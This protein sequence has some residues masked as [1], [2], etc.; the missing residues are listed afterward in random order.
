MVVDGKELI[1]KHDIADSLNE[2]FTT[3]ASSPLASQQSH[4]SPVDL[5]QDRLSA[6]S[7]HSFKFRAVSENDVFKVLRS[8]DTSKAIGA[9]AIPA[10]VIII[11]TLYIADLFN[12]SFPCGCFPS[13]LKTARVT[14]LFKGRSQTEHDNYRPIL[15]LH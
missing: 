11:R 7:N 8:M 2:Y 3:I 15:I 13:I 14:S 10:K 1:D 4:G 5:Q 9:D 6:I 12:A